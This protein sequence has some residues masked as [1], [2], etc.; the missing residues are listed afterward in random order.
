MPI[1]LIEPE[2]EPFICFSAIYRK[3]KQEFGL[4]KS[5]SLIRQSRQQLS[6]AIP[7]E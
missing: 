3:S 2:E 1:W 4:N 5:V 7:L 6:D